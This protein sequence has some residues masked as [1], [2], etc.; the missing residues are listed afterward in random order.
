MNSSDAAGVEELSQ[1]SEHTV[2]RGLLFI[3]EKNFRISWTSVSSHTYNGA[4][5]AIFQ[6]CYAALWMWRLAS[7]VLAEAHVCPT[8]PSW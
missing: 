4:D 3:S 8:L 6:V 2:V 5:S 1:N 7:H